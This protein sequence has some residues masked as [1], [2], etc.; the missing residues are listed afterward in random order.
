MKS[1]RKVLW[2]ISLIS[3]LVIVFGVLRALFLEVYLS[4][5][6]FVYFGVVHLVFPLLILQTLRMKKGVGR[7]VFWTLFALVYLIAMLGWIFPDL[8][9]VSG[10]FLLI[11]FLTTIWGM[12][13]F[14]VYDRPFYKW[15]YQILPITAAIALLIGMNDPVYGSHYFAIALFA[16]LIQ[17]LNGIVR[18]LRK[19]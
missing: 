9:K 19:A 4:N 11:F 16:L 2:I 18:I 1:T 12:V 5:V 13:N 15:V 3:F 10:P 17:C 8:L 14:M 6:V 7:I